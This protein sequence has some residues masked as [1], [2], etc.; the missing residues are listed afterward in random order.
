MGNLITK[1][2]SVLDLCPMT[3]IVSLFQAFFKSDFKLPDT[4]K[5]LI[6]REPCIGAIIQFDPA[7]Y[8]PEGEDP[9]PDEATVIELPMG[10]MEYKIATKVYGLQTNEKIECNN[11]RPDS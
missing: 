2:A 6:L 7:K 5:E 8:R 4:L 10:D 9:A 1:S 11:P 3:V